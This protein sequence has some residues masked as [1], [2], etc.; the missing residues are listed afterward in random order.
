MVKGWKILDAF[1][2]RRTLN[3]LPQFFWGHV[4]LDRSNSSN[5]RTISS[6]FRPIIIVNII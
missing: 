3:L 4:N 5:Y 6:H 1:L 2:N